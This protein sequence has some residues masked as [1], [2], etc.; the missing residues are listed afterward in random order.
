MT[1]FSGCGPSVRPMSDGVASPRPARR[2]VRGSAVGGLAVA[3]ALVAACSS[4]TRSP[5]AAST[6]SSGSVTASG[7][8]A[9]ESGGGSAGSQAGGRGGFGGAAAPGASGTIAAVQQG[10]FEV[11]STTSQTTVTF[12]SGTAIQQTV[13]GSLADIAPGVCVTAIAARPATSAGPTSSAGAAAGGSAGGGSTASGTQQRRT[14]PSMLT[15][16]TVAIQPATAGT[17]AALG[18]SGA[19]RSRT[20]APRTFAGRTPPTGAPSSRGTSGNGSGAVGSPGAGGFGGFG[21]IVS[22]QVAS[23]NGSTFTVT[24][25]AFT[26]GAGRGQGAA[27][28]AAPAVSTTTSTVTVTDATTYLKTAKAGSSAI[29]VGRC[30]TAFGPADDTGAIAATQIRISEPTA[31]SCTASFGAFG[32]FS[33]GG[34]QGG[35]PGSQGAGVSSAG[36]TH[37]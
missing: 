23:V 20:R 27:A 8:T 12:T 32:G 15:A 10:S 9:G 29:T 28:T 1:T 36:A 18:F 30:A 14:T 34:Q 2:A 37:A 13:K 3:L 5:A 11:Q 33:R 26:G 21:G 4:T 25:R 35:Q 22:G 7:A 24:A 16:T 19:G 6:P 31:G 17:C